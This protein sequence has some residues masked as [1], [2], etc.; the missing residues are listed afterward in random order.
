MTKDQIRNES[1][2]A[3]LHAGLES[4]LAV[5][6]GLFKTP[7]VMMRLRGRLSFRPV[8]QFFDPRYIAVFGIC[9]KD[10]LILRISGQNLC[11]RTKLGWE[12]GVGEKKSHV[13]LLRNF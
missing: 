10:H 11:Y 7:E 5:Q 13:F 6:N 9:E 2:I 12:I 8:N 4:G 3:S 1:L